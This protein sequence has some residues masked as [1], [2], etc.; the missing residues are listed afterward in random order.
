MK[1]EKIRKIIHFDLNHPEEENAHTMLEKVRY[2]QSKLIIKLVNDFF[3]DHDI[4]KDTPYHIVRKNVLEYIGVNPTF[5]QLSLPFNEDI[6]AI[7]TKIYMEQCNNN[8]NVELI[9]EVPRQQE[10]ITTLQPIQNMIPEEHPDINEK[11][12]PV[13]ISSE[14]YDDDEDDDISIKQMAFGFQSLIE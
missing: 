2:Y 4:T 1:K 13:D 3:E 6:L 8:T 5:S 12:S 10:E 7:A 9:K 14:E 11:I